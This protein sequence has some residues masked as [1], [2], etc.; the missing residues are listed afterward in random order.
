MKRPCPADGEEVQASG[1]EVQAE[2]LVNTDMFEGVGP[3]AR[4]KGWSQQ[5]RPRQA[6]HLFRAWF[7]LRPRGGSSRQ[8]QQPGKLTPRK[9]SH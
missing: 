5:P 7:Y 1:V 3:R 2:Y 6:D 8:L 9:T 4:P